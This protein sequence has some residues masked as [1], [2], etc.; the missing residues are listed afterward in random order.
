M[1]HRTCTALTLAAALALI[2]MPHAA[3]AQ[4]DYPARNIT[5]VVPVAPGSQ[6][7][8]FARMIAEPL[9]QKLGKS[10]VIEN[11][12]GGGQIIGTNAAA[13]A[14]ADGYTLVHGNLSGLIISPQLR[15]PR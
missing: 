11:R 14:K 1:T 13:K 3:T 12:P 7:D 10:I 4:G 8:I 2:A 15:Q 5:I 9:S 6:A